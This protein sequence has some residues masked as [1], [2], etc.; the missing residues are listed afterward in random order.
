[1]RLPPQ[2]T[3]PIVWPRNRADSCITP[4]RP[5][6]PD[7]SATLVDRVHWVIEDEVKPQTLSDAHLAAI[8]SLLSVPE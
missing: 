3:V 2:I 7:G 1:M 5:T 8:A 4:A 6:A